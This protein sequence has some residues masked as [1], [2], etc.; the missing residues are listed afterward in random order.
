MKKSILCILR[1]PRT[2]ELAPNDFIEPFVR[3]DDDNDFD[4]TE[5]ELMITQVS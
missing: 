1:K 4:Y 5:V 3:S 2:I